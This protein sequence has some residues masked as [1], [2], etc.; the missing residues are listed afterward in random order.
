[1]RRVILPFVFDFPLCCPESEHCSSV[2]GCADDLF[3]EIHF[4]TTDFSQESSCE[5]SVFS[6][7]PEYSVKL[8]EVSLLG[9]CGPEK[10]TE[11]KPAPCMPI[12]SM[13]NP[14]RQFS[15]QYARTLGLHY[16]A[17]TCVSFLEARKLLSEPGKSY[18][19]QSSFTADMRKAE[20]TGYLHL[21]ILQGE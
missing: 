11:E 10:L 2:L 8:E 16:A 9:I 7:L 4:V 17:E 21:T 3:E 13:Y 6:S 20:K 19:A 5:I 18:T 1:M 14:L 15:L 12:A